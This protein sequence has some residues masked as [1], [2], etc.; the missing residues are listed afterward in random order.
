MRGDIILGELF[1]H[2]LQ[3]YI[4]EYSCYAFIES[5]TGIGT[6]IKHALRY[7]FDELYSYEYVGQ[8]YE[9]CKNEIKDDRLTL[10]HTDTLSGLKNVLSTI[11]Q[12]D[13]IMFWLDAHFPGADFKFNDYDHLS[14]QPSLHMPLK[15]EIDIISSL[16]PNSRD[17]L[18]IDDLQ[19][20]EGDAG[21]EL[22][23]PSGFNDKYGMGGIGFIE[24]AYSKTHNFL[25][26]YR[27]Q[28]FLILTPV[29]DK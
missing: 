3:T 8:L 18:I 14:D 10:M 29:G 15:D 20:Y 21:V 26:D 16:R 7:P 23:N 27:H 1:L 25:R 22:P 2:N 12:N 4:D 11:D 17:V 24:E 13:P 19:I 5:G 28:G 9:H 6:G